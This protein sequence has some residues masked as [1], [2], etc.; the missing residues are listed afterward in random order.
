MKKRNAAD[1]DY[2]AA[3]GRPAVPLVE[4]ELNVRTRQVAKGSVRV[5]VTTETLHEEVPVV[6]SEDL[7]S[8]TRVPIDRPVDAPPTVRTEGDTMVVPIVDEVIIVQ[9]QLVLK[10][11]IHLR[12]ESRSEKRVVPVARRRQRALIK[13]RAHKKPA[14]T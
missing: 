1:S 11:E 10:E 13:R 12:R 7:V 14:R 8:I 5:E 9:R 6:V 3:S 4:E 2:H